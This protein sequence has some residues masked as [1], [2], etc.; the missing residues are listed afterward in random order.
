MDGAKTTAG[1]YG[2]GSMPRYD[3]LPDDEAGELEVI[4]LRLPTELKSALESIA[5]VETR[6]RQHK[7]RAGNVS[8]NQL[9]KSV[10]ERFVAGW[11]E[12]YSGILPLEVVDR[13]ARKLVLS[14]KSSAEVDRKARTVAER[15]LVEE[16]ARTAKK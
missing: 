14:E 5:T 2:G 11:A 4:T 10:I 9:V 8:V 7:K 3:W 1:G 15:R 13:S 16:R 12:E 6:M